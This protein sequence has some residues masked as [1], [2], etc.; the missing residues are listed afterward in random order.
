MTRSQLLYMELDTRSTQ[1]GRQGKVQQTAGNK[2]IET[3]QP[4]R[5]SGL[6]SQS[7]PVYYY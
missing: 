5:V 6:S 3:L 1:E 4:S 7:Y 2:Y